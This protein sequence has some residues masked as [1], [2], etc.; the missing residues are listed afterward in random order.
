M[1]IKAVGEFTRA[2]MID[3]LNK[4]NNTAAKASLGS[5]LDSSKGCVVGKYNFAVQGG[6]VGDIAL[7][8]ELG[9]TAKIPINAVITRAYVDVITEP[10]SGGSATVAAKAQSSAD[11]FDATAIA[12]LTAGLHEGN[13]TGAASEMVKATAERTLYITVATAALTAGKLNVHVEYMISD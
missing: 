13:M 3:I 4:M 7:V 12:S 5:A 6:A 8:D 2:A 11:L 10:T 1:P 9:A